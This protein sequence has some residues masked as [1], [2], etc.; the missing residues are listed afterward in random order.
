MPLVENHCLLLTDHVTKARPQPYSK[1]NRPPWKRLRDG[2]WS[3]YLRALRQQ[4][5]HETNHH[6]QI[7]DWDG[8]E[9]QDQMVLPPADFH[10]QFHKT[11]FLSE[12]VHVRAEDRA[13][14][15]QPQGPKSLKAH[16]RP[17]HVTDHP[18]A[19]YLAELLL[20]RNRPS[21]SLTALFDYPSPLFPYLHS[22]TW[23][24]KFLRFQMP[25]EKLTKG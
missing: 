16:P 25:C 8:E 7:G 3:L 10:L 5:L 4:S 23:T 1:C 24:K 18:G 11:H 6:C 20:G 17:P 14:Q 22:T 15:R 9:A 21:W 12:K 13:N 19:V 2:A